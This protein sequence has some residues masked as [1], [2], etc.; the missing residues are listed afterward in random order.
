M[1]KSHD[2][3]LSP[4]RKNIETSIGFFSLLSCNAIISM[5]DVC[6]MWS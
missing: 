6:Y 4:Q 2:A 5:S 3:I 1:T